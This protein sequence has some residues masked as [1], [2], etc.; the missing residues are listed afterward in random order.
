MFLSE[1]FG[2]EKL[3]R[4]EEHLLKALHLLALVS[5]KERKLSCWVFF[6]LQRFDTPT[7]HRT[8][9]QGIGIMH[10]NLLFTCVY[11]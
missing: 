8:R 4:K 3:Q 7:I 1:I 10:I 9:N 11:H 6:I 5:K 2:P